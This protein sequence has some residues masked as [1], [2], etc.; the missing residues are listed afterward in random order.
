MPYDN[1]QV[2]PKCKVLSLDAI[3]VLEEEVRELIRRAGFDPIKQPREVKSL[4]DSAIQDY[5]DR[6]LLSSMPRLGTREKTQRMLFDTF[7]GFGRLQ[8]FLDDPAVEE[9]W[10]NS[11]QQIYIARNG[12]AE[13]TSLTFSAQQIR[14]LVERMLKSSGR[15][16]DLSTPFVDASLPDGSRLHV[17][18]PD[19]GIVAYR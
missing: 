8:P 17:V 2:H 10:I 18:I 7:V 6:S 9:I 12:E 19:T 15:R 4:I 1:L 16:L 3:Q 11:P 5:D 14:D 13:L